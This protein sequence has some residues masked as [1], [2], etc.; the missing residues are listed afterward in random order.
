MSSLNSGVTKVQVKEI[1]SGKDVSLISVVFVYMSLE[2][3]IS[4][5]QRKEGRKNKVI[6]K[7]KRLPQ[8][9]Y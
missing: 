1:I 6:K 8:K 2:N 9:R 3:C 5:T 7:F 4:F